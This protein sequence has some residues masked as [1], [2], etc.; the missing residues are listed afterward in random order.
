MILVSVNV[1]CDSCYRYLLDDD[2]E[3]VSV[4]AAK[5][6]AAQSNWMEID[7]EHYCPRCLGSRRRAPVEGSLMKHLVETE[8]SRNR[9]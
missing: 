4:T 3:A 9:R 1:C 6:A 2:T 7:G 5:I 8:G